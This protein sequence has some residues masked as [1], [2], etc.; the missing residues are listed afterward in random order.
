VRTPIIVHSVSNSF[1]I[2]RIDPSLR[3][4]MPGVSRKRQRGVSLCTLIFMH[5]LMGHGRTFLPALIWKALILV[6]I[7]AKERERPNPN[8]RSCPH[9]EQLGIVGHMIQWD[10]C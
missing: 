7:T 8:P 6:M 5:R 1:S 3:I 9:H 10:L 4:P 2:Y